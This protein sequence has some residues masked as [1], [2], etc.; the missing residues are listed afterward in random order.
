MSPDLML[1][2]DFGLIAELIHGYALERPH[3]PALIHDERV[4]SYGAL[5]Q[6]MDRVAASLQ[7]DGVQLGDV[8]SI[9]A[10]SCVEYGAIFSVRCVPASLSH[11]S[12]P[13]RRPQRW[14][15]CSRTA[16]RS[17]CFSTTRS[18]LRSKGR[19]CPRRCGGFRSRWAIGSRR[20]TRSLRPVQIDPGA[21]FNIIYSSGT[22]GTPK[23]IVQSHRMRW[24]HVHRAA[25]ARYDRTAVTICS[26]PLYSNTTL[27]SFFPTLAMGGTVVLMAK[28]DALK[29]LQLAQRHERRTRCSCP[30]STSASWICRTSTASTCRASA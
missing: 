28:F 16:A 19:H 15:Q 14:R 20:R 4:L 6:L 25:L 1:Q 10:A 13:H 24:A 9:C 12:H 5:D 27:V 21:P 23:G 11:R 30:C 8:I 18:R 3:H 26:T 22:T 17:C 7:R 2:Q 29:F